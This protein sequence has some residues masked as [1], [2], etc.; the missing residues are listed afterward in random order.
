MYRFS[1]KRRRWDGNGKMGKGLA[2]PEGC[3]GLCS[4]IDGTAK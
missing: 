2:G 1:H 3:A 4:D